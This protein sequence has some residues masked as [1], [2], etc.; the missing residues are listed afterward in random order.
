MAALVTEWRGG[1]LVRALVVGC[2]LLLASC[3]HRGTQIIN[4]VEMDSAYADFFAEYR[5]ILPAERVLCVYGAIRNDTAFV[6]FIKPA[7][8]RHRSPTSA[9]FD[10]CPRSAREAVTAQ[11]LGT[12]HNHKV[13]GRTDDLCRFSDVDD[14][15]FMEEKT[16]VI[17][18]LSCEGKL[19]ARSKN[20]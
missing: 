11:Y 8:M 7:K 14:R 1:V 16:N 12:W 13:E 18:L 19:M 3:V 20:R 6:N 17:E 2:I 5:E 4:R 10:S 9:S 15:S